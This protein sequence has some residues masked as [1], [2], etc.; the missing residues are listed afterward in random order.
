M[1]L[2]PSR[3]VRLYC[4]AALLLLLGVPAIGEILGL[5]RWHSVCA[6]EFSQDSQMLVAGLSTGRSYNEDNHRLIADLGQTIALFDARTGKR[7][8]NLVQLQHAGPYSGTSST[9]L[10]RFI[11]FSPDG[12]TLAVGS[13]DGTVQLWD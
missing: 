4:L 10:G 8:G 9:P 13:W 12:T 3:K 7:A 11:T 1:D 6:L 5:A 2:R